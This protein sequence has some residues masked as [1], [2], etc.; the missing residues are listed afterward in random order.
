MREGR[1][2]EMQI[3]VA[4]CNMAEFISILPALPSSPLGRRRQRGGLEG[5]GVGERG[6]GGYLGIC[7]TSSEEGESERG[8]VEKETI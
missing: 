7:I 1:G 6:G 3:R 8:G 5:N 2:G 4:T